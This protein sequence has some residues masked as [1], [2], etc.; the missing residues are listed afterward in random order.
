MAYK[1]GKYIYL[2][3]GKLPVGRIENNAYHST[4]S[5]EKHFYRNKPGWAI[6]AEILRY[7]AKHNI[8]EIVLEVVAVSGNYTT[9]ALLADFVQRGIELNHVDKQYLLRDKF[10]TQQKPT[11][12]ELEVKE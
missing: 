5:A 12:L 10:W 4:R 8:L 11:Q 6:S 2:K 9:K 3:N 1:L 7:L